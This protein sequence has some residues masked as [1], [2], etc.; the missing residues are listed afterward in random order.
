MPT[1]FE[2]FPVV[3]VDGDKIVRADVPFRRADRS[4]VSNKLAKV[5][6]VNIFNFNQKN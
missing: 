2:T 4:I 6:K 3:P 1:L 5:A